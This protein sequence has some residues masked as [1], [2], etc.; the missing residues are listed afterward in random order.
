MFARCKFISI[1][2]SL[3]RLACCIVTIFIFFITNK[4]YCQDVRKDSVIVSKDSIVLN[5]NG[6]LADSNK[7]KP[8]V[9]DSSRRSSLEDSLGI[10]IS[11]DALPSI[12]KAKAKDSA[13][14]DMKSNLFFLY[15]KAQVNYEDLQLTAGQVTYN[16]G[17]N[18]VTAAPY[19]VM[20]DSTDEKQTFTQGKEKFTYDSLQYNFKSKR[21]IV[22][23]VHSQYGE[24]YV[25][26][27]QV[28]RNPDATIYGAR[29]IYT[30]CALDTPHFGIRASR[31]KVI[32]GKVIVSGP[33]NICIENVPTP[34]FLPFGLFPVTNKQKSGF[35]LPTYTIE[36]QR[37]LGLLNGGYYFHLNEHVDLLAQTN[38][39]SKGSYALSGVSD[40]SSI[41]RYRGLFSVSYAYNKTG[42]DYEPGGSTKRDI[43]VNWRHQS[44][45][46]SVPGQSFNASVQ[47]GTSS[48]YSNNSYD[49]NQILQNQ[50]QSNVSYSKNWLGTPLGLTI[51]ALH[52]QNTQTKQV[53]VTLPDVNFHVTQINPFQSK[54]SIGTRWYD[55]I[56][57]SYNVEVLNRTTFYDTSFDMARMSLRDFQ[58]G[59]HHTIPISASYTVARYI[60]MSFSVNYNEYW[61]S[62]KIHREYDLVEK[63]VD[64][65]Q[66]FNFYSARDFNTGVN[67][68][69]RIYGMKL[70]KHGKLRG[71]R[72][73][74]TPNA[75]LT[76]HPN[77]AASPFDYYYRTI[78]DSSR[79]LYYESPFATSIVG[80]PPLGKAGLVSMGLNNNLQIKVRSSKDTVTGYRNITLIDGLGL[81]TS[82]NPVADSF[83]WS[84]VGAS[85]RTNVL[86]KVNISA[87]ATFDP[88]KF[89]YTTGRRDLNLLI[90]K[91]QGIVR[92]TGGAVSLGTNFHSK[93][94]GG[95]GS[96][97]NGAEYARIMRN[98]GYN[99]YVDFNI[100]W[101]LNVNYS[102][103]ATKQ[104]SY[105]SHHDTT[106]V[107][108]T[109]TFDGELQVTERWK[110][111]ASSG[112]N[113][114]Y[115]QL[116]LTSIDIYRDLHCLA[117]HLQT[118]P[119][120]PRKSFS[121]TLNVKATVL[122]DLKLMRR[123]D[124]RD[125]PY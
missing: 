63:R 77:F 92:F 12:V 41:Y 124:F 15:G 46:K 47:A 97:T 68:S 60:N 101:S 121:F 42:E 30:T 25:A 35:I 6:T 62:N 20:K 65:N 17:S 83:Q 102:L 29:S 98:A 88:Y 72:H 8:V 66:T 23:N 59:A 95:A 99:D 10:R 104:Y 49:A 106:V 91:G 7:A 5:S 76:Y 4:G 120:G 32:P 16:Q 114:D 110:V 58:M 26:S 69:T 73:V 57:A 37:G 40:Y 118:V 107:T 11:K 113:F 125:T 44:D 119:F 96:P 43:M 116:T 45:G 33:A 103:S 82:Y 13:V 51:S 117:M 64:T 36:Q 27:E 84:T 115:H 75:G 53:D 86:D 1:F 94:K 61:Y 111:H 52:R 89:D 28:K 9:A 79:T 105:F 38:V 74:L 100:P 48:Y 31:I 70:F 21:A 80:L 34:L 18:V 85:F 81:G 123:R 87:S 71:I 78:L 3:Y 22:R 24:G 112:Y 2:Q 109:L 108:Q 90:D 19:E 93:P 55:K 14:M 39:F 50:Y 67:F 54:H 56:T 122:Q